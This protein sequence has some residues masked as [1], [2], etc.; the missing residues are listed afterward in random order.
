MRMRSGRRRLLLTPI[1]YLPAFCS[2]EP[3]FSRILNPATADTAKTNAI[4]AANK[5]LPKT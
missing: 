1:A 4:D 3:R 5:I 2:L